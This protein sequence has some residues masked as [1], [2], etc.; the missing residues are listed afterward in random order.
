MIGWFIETIIAVWAQI[1]LKVGAQDNITRVPPHPRLST[2][3]CCRHLPALV[4]VFV[5][6][7]NHINQPGNEIVSLIIRIEKPDHC[8]QSVH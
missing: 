4:L 8:I 5:S 3:F 1:A 7:L 2:P 6:R